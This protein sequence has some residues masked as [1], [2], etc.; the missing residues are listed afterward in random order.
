MPLTEKE[1]R[2]LR[3][4]ETVV[5]V[6]QPSTVGTRFATADFDQWSYQDALTALRSL[7]PKNY[8]LRR[9][10][11]VDSEHFSATEW[12]GPGNPVSNSKIE[13]QFA[14]D[15]AI[16]DALWNI[17]NAFREAQIGFAPLVAVPPG[18]EVPA[19]TRRRIEEATA[20]ITNLWD[21][22]G[23][24]ELTQDRLYTSGWAGFSA[25]RPRV[26]QRFMVRGEGNTVG[27]L[28]VSD[29]TEAFE[30][31]YV[32]AP[33]PASCGVYTEPNT[34]D[35]VAIFFG[36]QTV[37]NAKGEV[38]EQKYVELVYLDP[39]RTR[40]REAMTTMRLVYEDPGLQGYSAN[41]A[42]GGR[43]LTAQMV[44]RA[45]LT[46]AVLRTQRQL[47]LLTSLITRM[48][49]TAAF[50]GRY[51]QN[52]KPIGT[53]TLWEEG[54]AIP[55]GSFLE[56]DEEDR[57]WLVTP[58][59]RTLGANTTTDLVGLDKYNT[60]GDVVGHESPGVILEDP[61]DPTAYIN[62]AE[63][64][65]R[66]LLRMCSQ[67][68]LAGTSNFEVSGIAYEQARA[69]FEKDLNKR[70]VAEEGML[71]DL[72]TNILALA[73]YIADQPGYFTDNLRVVVDQHV[74]AGPRSPDSVRLDHEA[75]E[76]GL[77]SRETAMSKIGVEDLE[78]E[79]ERIKVSPQDILM[80]LEKAVPAMTNYDD[81]GL[82][83]L[84]KL[85]G[86]P[87]EFIDVI[88]KEEPEPPAASTTG[89]GTA[90]GS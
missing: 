30:Y 51:T 12:V 40:D 8:E 46:D 10:Y 65:R 38:N 9:K 85:F 87:Q 18:Q 62:A 67:G 66:R 80:I 2:E 23:L 72:I 4:E 49:E 77:L 36:S 86:L 35:R 15:D 64:V 69:V 16:G 82:K 90:S 3:E 11:A 73:E 6:Q 81:E 58:V 29:I 33:D 41:L 56:R 78:A 57:Q 75:F 59:E 17:A 55:A 14:P 68:H 5:T 25:L 26:P 50:R 44:A 54:E 42:L 31:I 88:K 53:R 1:S 45:L 47:N 83:A 84:L 71:R 28:P 24:H 48:G 76:K 22:V 63:S 61:V 19:M 60:E 70:R 37:R 89:G 79:Q 34:K 52:A 13:K 20:A 7:R 21:R 27:F 39:L 32:D 43:I 74:D